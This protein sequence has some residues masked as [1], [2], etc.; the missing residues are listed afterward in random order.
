MVETNMFVVK[1]NALKIFYR[2]VKHWWLAIK[3]WQIKF[4]PMQQ[5][6]VGFSHLFFSFLFSRFWYKEELNESFQFA[7][8]VCVLETASLIYK[9]R[10]MM[11]TDRISEFSSIKAFKR[12][13][14]PSLV[15]PVPPKKYLTSYWFGE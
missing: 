9:E 7:F 6:F 3:L 13:L 2:A 8:S 15:Y 4:V 14:D 5:T 10:L 12:L 1:T 11:T